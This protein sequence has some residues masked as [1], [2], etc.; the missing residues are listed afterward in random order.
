VFDVSLRGKPLVVLSN[1][2]GR[3]IAR[4]AEAKALGIG[5]GEPWHEMRAKYQQLIHRSSNYALYGDMSARVMSIL[6]AAAPACEAYSIDEVFL[7]WT[8]VTDRAGL[9]REVRT[10]IREWTGLPVCVGIGSTKTRAKFA[11]HVAKKRAELQ[12]FLVE[13]HPISRVGD[14]LNGVTGGAEGDDSY[15]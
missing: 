7:D 11:N 13:D 5:M 9:G 1:N 14:H 6:S 4:S 15:A 8:T 3:V 12:D 10:Q 2:N